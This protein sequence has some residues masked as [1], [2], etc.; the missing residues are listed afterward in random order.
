MTGRGI[1]HI[2]NETTRKKNLSEIIINEGAI[3]AEQI[4]SKVLKDV[5]KKKGIENSKEIRLK[6]LKGGKD[7]R[8][9]VGKIKNDNY[10]MV[11][12]DVAA[13]IK[14]GLDLGKNETSTLLPILRKSKVKVEKNIMDV[15]EEV[16]STLEDEYESNENGI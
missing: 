1:P 15:L 2:C 13:K 8:V 14:K 4:V 16:G 12:A 9:T 10:G 7:L 11:D 5:R 6:Q 3:A